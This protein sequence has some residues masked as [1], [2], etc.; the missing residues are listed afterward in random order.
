MGDCQISSV[1]YPEEYSCII[2]GIPQH[3]IMLLSVKKQQRD[4]QVPL[5]GLFSSGTV[6]T[7][8]IFESQEDRASI[9]AF[10]TGLKFYSSHQSDIK[11]PESLHFGL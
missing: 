7:R 11:C 3:P 6:T 2:S 1:L 8:V 5:L 9:P 4:V 10:P